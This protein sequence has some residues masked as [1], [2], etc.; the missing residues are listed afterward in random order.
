MLI[1]KNNMN[2]IVIPEPTKIPNREN[3]ERVLTEIKRKAD[4]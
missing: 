2:K 1:I 3:C 4:L